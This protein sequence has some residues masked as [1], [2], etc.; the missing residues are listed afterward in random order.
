MI[1]LAFFLPEGLNRVIQR[2]FA[3]T[4]PTAKARHTPWTFPIQYDPGTHSYVG[5]DLPGQAVKRL[6]EEVQS[7]LESALIEFRRTWSLRASMGGFDVPPRLKACS[8]Q[9]VSR[10]SWKWRGTHPIGVF[11]SRTGPE[12]HAHGY[13]LALT[14]DE[15]PAVTELL[16][17][18]HR[19][20]SVTAHSPAPSPSISRILAFL[21]SCHAIG[22][23]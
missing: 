3:Q 16:D 9:D 12:L 10:H 2:A 14:H 11:E 20:E 23:K 15:R 22:A 7:S 1:T 19:G 21:A 18:L 17:R 5:V 4:Y 13:S 6:N 8:E